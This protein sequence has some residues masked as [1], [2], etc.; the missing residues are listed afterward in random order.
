MNLLWEL[1]IELYSSEIVRVNW[2]PLPSALIAGGQL[3]AFHEY[4]NCQTGVCANEPIV[5]SMS[6]SP[7]FTLRYYRNEE[8]IERI[9]DSSPLIIHTDLEEGDSPATYRF[10][11]IRDSKCTGIIYEHPVVIS[12]HPLPTGITHGCTCVLNLV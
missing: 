8:L 5:V 3:S 9:T 12:P 11:S 1:L 6:G 2:Y 10:E 7:P 4:S